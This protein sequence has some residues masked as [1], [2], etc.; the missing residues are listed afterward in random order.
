MI[1]SV[2]SRMEMPARAKDDERQ[3]FYKYLVRDI[4]YRKFF[5][6]FDE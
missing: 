3:C 5:E 4:F 2:F 1:L 6:N